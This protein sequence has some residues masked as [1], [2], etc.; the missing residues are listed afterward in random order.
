MVDVT[1]VRTQHR[2]AEALIH[3]NWAAEMEWTPRK[4]SQSHLSS[5]LGTCSAPGHV[6]VLGILL[7]HPPPPQGE[8]DI[9][10]VSTR[11]M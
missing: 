4:L 3:F 1:L 10:Q 11:R 2:L 5:V 6:L 8:I 9:S 7:S